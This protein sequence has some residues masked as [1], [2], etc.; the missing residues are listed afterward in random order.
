M[1][2]D[3]IYYGSFSIDT[4][5]NAIES[6]VYVA[7]YGTVASGKFSFSFIIS[8]NTSGTNRYDFPFPVD[9]LSSL[10]ADSSHKFTLD[11]DLDE[12]QDLPTGSYYL[13]FSIDPFDE[14]KESNE[15]TFGI[16]IHPSLILVMVNQT[17]LFTKEQGV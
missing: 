5:T 12:F 4:A 8:A 13:T 11:S 16:L 1:T 9:T 2:L 14:V 10:A 7:N 6:Y 3:T 17:S 15:S